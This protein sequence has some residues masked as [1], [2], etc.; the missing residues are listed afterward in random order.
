[1][2][3]STSVSSWS[4]GLQREV[5]TPLSGASG[6]RVPVASG[7]IGLYERVNVPLSGPVSFTWDRQWPLFVVLAVK[8]RA[9][10]TIATPPS[11]PTEPCFALVLCG[12][13]D[14]WS[15]T[16][17]VGSAHRPGPRPH[18]LRDHCSAVKPV[19]PPGLA[20]AAI[21]IGRVCEADANL[22]SLRA[23]L[24]GVCKPSGR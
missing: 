10:D 18:I 16:A 23:T 14:S 4:S 6:T 21:V 5:Q 2:S 7:T 8:R 13:L 24:S 19:T 9:A 22:C 3:P 12:C 17:F 1:M 15:Q 11:P 20:L